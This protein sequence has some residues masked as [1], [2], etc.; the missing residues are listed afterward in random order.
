MWTIVGDVVV[1]IGIDQWG[2]N[3]EQDWYKRFQFTF[4]QFSIKIYICSLKDY[5]H[6]SMNNICLELLMVKFYLDMSIIMFWP[7]THCCRAC[8]GAQWGTWLV[9]SNM[10]DVSRTTTTS[11]SSTPIP[12]SGLVRACLPSPSVSIRVRL[13]IEI[14]RKE[15]KFRKVQNSTSHMAWQ[16]NICAFNFHQSNYIWRPTRYHSW[17][18]P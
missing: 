15:T 1:P 7:V 4:V 9:K 14:S 3:G 10:V 12:R 11:V 2:T 5:I 16:M 18:P 17:L 6:F 8:P 13:L